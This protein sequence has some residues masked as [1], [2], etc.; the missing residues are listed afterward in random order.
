[1]Y[2][3]PEGH[4]LAL[5]FRPMADGTSGN[6]T[7]DVEMADYDPSDGSFTVPGREGMAFRPGSIGSPLWKPSGARHSTSLRKPRRRRR[8]ATTADS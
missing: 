3:P 7:G 8:E 4:K 6:P 5:Y 1:M 2:K